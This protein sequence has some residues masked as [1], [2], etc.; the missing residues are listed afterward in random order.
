M[1]S[2]KGERGEKDFTKRQKPFCNVYFVTNKD[3]HDN[4][5]EL[6]YLLL[7]R[8]YR[9]GFIEFNDVE[10]LNNSRGNL[11]EFE[12]EKNH[13]TIVKGYFDTLH[14]LVETPQG[15]AYNLYKYMKRMGRLGSRFVVNNLLNILN[16][17]KENIKKDPISKKIAGENFMADKD[18]LIAS[19]INSCPENVNPADWEEMREFLERNA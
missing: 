15:E 5:Y 9:A 2:L 17:A 7:A 18:M 16:T 4:A 8:Y 10:A 6:A 19:L 14:K 11:E 3:D 1:R 13:K 12:M